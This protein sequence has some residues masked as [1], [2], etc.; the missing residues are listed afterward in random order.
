MKYELDINP[1]KRYLIASDVIADNTIKPWKNH[2]IRVSMGKKRD[3]YYQKFIRWRKKKNELVMATES[4]YA[5]LD[6]PKTFNCVFNLY[7]PSNFIKIPIS[8]IHAICDGW[9]PKGQLVYGHKHIVVFRFQ[10][11]IPKVVHKLKNGDTIKRGPKEQKIKLGF[12]Q[13][14]D[15]KYISDKLDDD[16]YQ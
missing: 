12:C 15:F 7:N 2:C 8:M 10:N 14:E 16:I 1:R 6:I 11:A 13:Y 5:D 3:Q 9:L 4:P